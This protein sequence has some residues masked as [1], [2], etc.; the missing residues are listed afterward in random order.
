[1]DTNAMIWLA[2][3]Q[4]RCD[5]PLQQSCTIYSQYYY[6]GEIRKT[7]INV[8]AKPVLEDGKTNLQLH[9]YV[10]K[11]SNRNFLVQRKLKITTKIQYNTLYFDVYLYSYIFLVL[12]PFP[13]R[14]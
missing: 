3:G 6:A 7:K 1:M 11:Q 5:L 12:R 2:T 4:K 13:L 8:L 10:P 14:R 9:E